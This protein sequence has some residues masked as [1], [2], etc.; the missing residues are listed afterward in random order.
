MTGRAAHRQLHAHRQP[1]MS[2]LCILALVAYLLLLPQ[3][4][5]ANPD[6]PYDG[7]WSGAATSADAQCKAA[8]VTLTVEGKVVVGQARFERE[9]SNINGTVADDGRF[10]ATIGF[11]PITGR[12]AADDFQG[13]FKNFGC[14]WSVQLKRA[15]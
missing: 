5:S 2:R 9:V 12:F 4:S 14:E 15:G 1:Q 13:V 10:G 6:G 7:E 8:L 3:L 11:Q